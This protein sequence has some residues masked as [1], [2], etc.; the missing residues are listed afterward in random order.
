LFVH[1]SR[2]LQAT[3]HHGFFAKDQIAECP[4]A[5]GIK[6]RVPAGLAAVELHGT[7]LPE[8]TLKSI[9][10]TG[11]TLKGPWG[12]PVGKG[13]CS[14]KVVLRQ[15]FYIYANVRPAKTLPRVPSRCTDVDRVISS[16][17]E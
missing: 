16:W 14:V 10:K 13:F 6:E 5:A 1:K 9:E 3:D 8:E 2:V 17:Q 4:H 7:P 12:T 11:V 15:H